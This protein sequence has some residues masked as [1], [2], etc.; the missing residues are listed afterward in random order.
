M[1]VENR[2]GAHSTV[3]QVLMVGH[4]WERREPS[5]LCQQLSGTPPAGRRPWQ[6]G[7]GGGVP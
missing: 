7:P 5:S 6:Q 3:H 1:E 2:H 4:R